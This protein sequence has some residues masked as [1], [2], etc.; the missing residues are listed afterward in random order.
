MKKSLACSFALLALGAVAPLSAGPVY[1]P[2]VES[3]KADGTPLATELSITN[4]DGEERAF[5]SAFLKVGVDGT[6]TPAV[7][8]T[9]PAE[10]AFYLDRAVAGGESG[11]L[12]IDAEPGMAVNAWI[13]SHRANRTFYTGVPVINAD[14]AVAAGSAT[15]LNGLRGDREI[16]SL[17][18]VNL[19]REK[20]ACQVD[21]L[22]ADGSAI[23]AGVAVE[24]PALSMRPFADA[25][26]L[27]NEKAATNARVTCDQ[28]FYAY[29]VGIDPETTE[30]SFATPSEIADAARFERKAAPRAGK[31][32]TTYNQAGLYHNATKENPKKVVRIPVPSNLRADRVVAEFSVNVG[33]WNPRLKSGAH[34]MMWFHRGRFRSNTL[35]NINALGPKK[36]MVKAN[37]NLDI[38]AGNVTNAKAGLQFEQGKTYRVLAIYDAANKAVSLTIS[39][40]GHTLKIL[41]FNGTPKG[42]VIEISATGLLAEFGHFNNQHLPEVASLG[43]KFSDLRVDVQY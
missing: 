8:E 23:G 4:F 14:I 22:R 25:L 18:V 37:Q 41:R 17:D 24:V 30:V 16:A 42:R 36:D 2:V 5:T 6:A 21:F 26:G 13:K 43:W 1:V 38:P 7:R 12:E 28:M 19:G 40:D 32:T 29:A 11:L 27:D 31:A 9:V 39:Q 10:K 33:P 35:I 3:L 34:G 20:A 15:F